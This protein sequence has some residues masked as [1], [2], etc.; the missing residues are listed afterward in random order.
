MR[1]TKFLLAAVVAVAGAPAFAADYDLQ[2][3]ANVANSCDFNAGSDVTV[4]MS[5]IRTG[6]T[7]TGNVQIWCTNGYAVQV[8]AS[9]AN[10]YSLV[11]GS[12]SIAYTF[13][14][15]GAAFTN[16]AFTGTGGASYSDIPYTLTFAAQN[17]PAGSYSDTI[18]FT[19]AP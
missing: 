9:S 3:S 19:V 4:D 18:T 15:N 11:D 16:V 17:P 8:S 13:K 7:Q 10:S 12:N 6:V 5:G 1:Y 2:V 14:S